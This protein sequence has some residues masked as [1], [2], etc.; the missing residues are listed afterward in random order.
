MDGREIFDCLPLNYKRKGKIK[1]VSMFTEGL[2]T[3]HQK[4]KENK[5]QKTKKQT[6]KKN[7]KSKCDICQYIIDNS[8]DL[9]P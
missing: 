3:K 8:F 7:Q 5:K 9:R 1:R 2:N 4:V 6:N